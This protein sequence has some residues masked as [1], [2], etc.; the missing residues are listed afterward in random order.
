MY[1]CLNSIS[2]K[3]IANFTLDKIL[4]RRSLLST[5]EEELVYHELGIFRFHTHEADIYHLNPIYQEQQIVV[6]QAEISLMCKD[7]IYSHQSICIHYCFRK[8][9]IGLEIVI[10][11][12]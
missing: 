7:G 3:D 10:K 1:K 12:F 11:I 4:F 8:L 6:G 5:S 2:H 9:S